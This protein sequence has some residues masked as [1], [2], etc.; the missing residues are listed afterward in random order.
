MR[1]RSRTTSTGTKIIDHSGESPVNLVRIAALI[2][3][4]IAMAPASSRGQ[5]SR[6]TPDS[7]IDRTVEADEADTPRRKL[8]H[9]N[10]YDAPITTLRFAV[11]FMYDFA[12]FAQDDETK[13]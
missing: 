7:T 12:T 8:V 1:R 2:A 5:H 10:E 4:I 3:L 9:W 11:N 13:Q 6:A